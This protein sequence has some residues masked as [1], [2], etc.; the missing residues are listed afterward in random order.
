MEKITNFWGILKTDKWMERFTMFMDRNIQYCEVLK[1][2]QSN[3]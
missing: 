3:L 2:L 1:T